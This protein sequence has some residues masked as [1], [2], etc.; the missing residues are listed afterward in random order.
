MSEPR[1]TKLR[2]VGLAGPDFA[3]ERNFLREPWGLPEVAADGQLAYFRAEGSTEPF[4]TRWR[5]AAARGLDVIGFAADSRADVD[6]LARKLARA[7]VKPIS[8]PHRLDSPGG[9]YGF[10]CFDGDGHAL[11]ISSDVAPVP[12]RALNRG[13]SIPAMLSH[14]VLHTPDLKKAVAFYEEQLGFKV[15]DWLGDFMSFLRCN[16]VHHSIAFIPGPPSLNHVAY[17]MRD[18][19]EMM[20][21]AG[22]LMKNKVPLKWGPGRHTAGNNTF[23]YFFDPVGNSLEYT[24]EV[25]RVDD[26]TWQP[27]VY[28][29]G[30]EITDQWGTSVLSDGPQGMGKPAPD[31]AL[32]QAP[33][34]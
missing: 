11:E 2:Y 6:A 8:E 20:R 16:E 31:P 12:A 17:E 9:G 29:P 14:V 3:T 30:F 32:W 24:A 27:T 26:A 21:G 4:I 28:P 5:G 18:M 22:R 1:V 19:D 13:E 7:G 34:V 15:S 23:S 10:R 33:P 25:D